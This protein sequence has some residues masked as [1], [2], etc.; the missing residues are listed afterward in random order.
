[1][2]GRLFLPRAAWL[3][4]WLLTALLALWTGSP[5]ALALFAALTVLPLLGALAAFFVRKKLRLQLYFS[6]LGTRGVPLAGTLRVENPTWLPVGQVICRVQLENRL[7]GETAYVP[8]ALH[9]GV[10]GAAEM[11]LE[12]SSQYCGYIKLRTGRV[13]VSDL[14]GCIRWRVP[15]G[16]DAKLTALP[17]LPAVN[18]LMTYPALTPDDG[19]AWLEGRKGSDYT[20]TLQLREY[21]PGDSIKQIHWKLSSKLDKTIVR[22][23]SFPVSRSL[24][25]FWDKTA[26]VAEAAEMNAMAE[27][28]CGISRA[29][30]EQGFAYTLAWNDGETVLQTPV[31]SEDALLQTMPRLLKSGCRDA[32]SSALSYLD[33]MAQPY[34]KVLYF[35]AA[36]PGE[37]E[38]TCFAGSELTVLCCGE[39]AQVGGCRVIAFTP[40]NYLQQ[41]Q[42]LELDA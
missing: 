23:P 13:Q 12:F 33:D 28:V 10:R 22:D 38:L 40:E 19:E 30:S 34:S 14:T 1:M 4:V 3:A 16:V 8:V 20:Q 11:A 39:A 21:V 24:L 5:A 37:A 25:L 42:D 17:E 36:C 31:D 26:R 9:P 32:A 29:A 2:N 18:L 15:L 35:T 7:T 27:C 6:P 41:L